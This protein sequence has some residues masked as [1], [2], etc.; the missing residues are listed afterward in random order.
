MS[1]DSY[2]GEFHARPAETFGRVTIEKLL[3]IH[4]IHKCHFSP[5]SFISVY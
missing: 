4:E 1:P 3:N 2:R 5:G